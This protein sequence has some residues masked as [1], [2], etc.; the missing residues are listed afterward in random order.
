MLVPLG[1][2]RMGWPTV[3]R[4]VRRG[5]FAPSIRS[6]YLAA[7]LSVLLGLGVYLARN[8]NAFIFVTPAPSFPDTVTVGQTFPAALGINN[9]STPPESTTNPSLTISAID[10]YP[11]CTTTSVDCTG[12][13]AESGVFARRGTGSGSSI[14]AGTVGCDGTWTIVP[15]TGDPNP[16]SRY[17]FVPPLGEGTL[18][19]PTGTT[20][21]VTYTATTRRVPTTD[22]NAGAPN[23][24][25][26]QVASSTATG[27]TIPPPGV[28]NSGTDQTTVLR[29]T[30]GLS[31]T[32]AQSAAQIPATTT[33]TATLSPPP[34]PAGAFGAPP[35]GTMTFNLFGPFAAGV[36]P[37]CTGAPFASQT[38]PVN[39]GGAYSTPT[40]V[41][42]TAPGTYTWV[43]TYSGDAN[44]IGSSTACGDPSETLT[45]AA[46]ARVIVT[47]AT[48]TITIGSTAS[49]TATLRGGFNPTGTITFTAFGPNNPTCTGAPV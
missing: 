9:S 24:Q 7:L 33:D 3:R 22:V 15:N 30:P 21:V 18:Q 2:Q 45:F 37:V 41:N 34:P 6:R 28:R 36:A 48:P 16:A 42:I 25:T 35:T 43:A 17:R 13:S 23:V 27:P 31:T 20:C 10:L 4:P 32:A 46:A 47:Q 14:G 11:A 40:P 39:G 5:G 26:N 8:A 19:L 1:G 49:D 12:G 29:A 38:V 44:Y